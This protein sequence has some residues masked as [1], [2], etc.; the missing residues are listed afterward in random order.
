MAGKITAVWLLVTVYVCGCAFSPA[1]PSP[2]ESTDIVKGS[3]V[4]LRVSAYA[5]DAG[6]PWKHRDLSRR[7]S[8]GC[9]VGE[10]QVLT[11]AHDI[12]DAA[13][14]EARCYGQNEYV[15]ATVKVIDYESNLCLLELDRTTMGG[16]L[17]PVVFQD[18][19]E[20]GADVSF[21]R[22]SS[23]GRVFTGR[24]YLDRARITWSPRSHGRFLN[25]VVANVSEPAGS[26]QLFYRGGKPIGIG[27]GSDKESKQSRII[28]AELINRFLAD[29]GE[30]NYEGF[31]AVG[32]DVED[33]LDPALRAYLKMPPT[34]THGVYVN[35]VYNLG[36][37]A[38]VL[39]VADVVLAIDGVEISARGRY[40]DVEFGRISF[41][42]LLTT[43]PPGEQVP[44]EI[45]R[46]GQRIAVPVETSNFAV[47]DM[48]VPYHGH[49]QQ[50]QYVIIAGFVLQR[51]TRPYLAGWGKDWSGK[52]SPH[53]YHY[54]RDLAFKPTD[55]R[56]QIVVLSYVLPAPINMGYQQLR[57]LVVT[58]FNGKTIRSIG[59]ILE[60]RNLDPQSKYHL[61]EFEHDQPVVVIPRVEAAAADALIAS[62]YGID[63]LINVRG[64]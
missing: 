56:R 26:G 39:K 3:L 2:T 22:L 21:Y 20:K 50:P 6:Q 44:F 8:Y 43:R 18:D 42:H 25:Y 58:K 40:S 16:P 49:D 4:Y 62:R 47:D 31:S 55:D 12:S 63:K 28:P 52:V 38:G 57:Q 32:F 41:E 59:D 45:W 23:D 30:G 37:G 36:T 33:L 7:G 9:A 54:Y 34:L 46:D 10:S 60:A 51:L 11:T 35:D 53:L 14:I 29:G 1:K 61:I 64:E 48:L 17:S 27:S 19:Y 13:L 15:R 24:G 5:Y